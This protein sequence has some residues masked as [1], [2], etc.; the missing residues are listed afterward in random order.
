MNY[1]IQPYN[2]S[3]KFL[4]LILVDF[5]HF[6]TSAP[7]CVQPLNPPKHKIPIEIP[8]YYIDTLLSPTGPRSEYCVGARTENRQCTGTKLLCI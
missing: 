5:S 7:P 2:S 8:P 6:A 1:Y 4:I 3:S